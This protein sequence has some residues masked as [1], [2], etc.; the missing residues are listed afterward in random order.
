MTLFIRQCL[1]FTR[2]L[3]TP[4]DDRWEFNQFFLGWGFNQFQAWA[5]TTFIVPNIRHGEGE[6]SSDGLVSITIQLENVGD[7]YVDDERLSG[8][9]YG[10]SLTRHTLRLQPGSRHTLSVRVVHEVRI[11][12]GVILPPPS[13]FKCEL[14]VPF[15]YGH[16]GPHGSYQPMVQVVR[17]GT[18]GII[19]MDAVD[20]VLA[21]EYISVALRNVGGQSVIIKSVKVRRGS[22]VFEAQLANQNKNGIQIFP[23]THRPIA[24]RLQKLSKSAP[25][26]EEYRSEEF[27]L[28]FEVETLSPDRAGEEHIGFLITEAFSIAQR[29]WGEPYMYTFQD[30]DRTVHY[31]AAIPPSNPE[32]Q[33]SG[34]APVL[35]AL[36]GAGKK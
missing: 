11:F 23:S 12:G 15:P 8:D 17:E 31:A 21:G 34:S 22:R 14:R 36:H 2:S 35:I 10:Y 29:K 20:G 33:P 3:T 5:R 19:I 24:I 1:F 16:D 28:Q 6:T 7:F 32:S 13:K 18:G 4:S 26:L 30:F 25:V 27:T 9:W